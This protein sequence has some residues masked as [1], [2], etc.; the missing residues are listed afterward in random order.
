MIPPER[1]PPPPP[2]A[3][4]PFLLVSGDFVQTGGMDLGNFHLARY[5]ARQG[6][7]VH[8][9]SHRVDPELLTYP[10][11]VFHRAPRPCGLHLSGER[12]LRRLGR[13]VASEPALKGARCVVNGGNC[14]LPGANWVHYV[15]AASQPHGGPGT[16]R[17]WKNRLSHRLFLRDEA[18]ALACARLIIVNSE[19]TRDDL[20]RHYRLPRERLHLVYYGTDPALFYPVDDAARQT[21]RRTLGLPLHKRLFVFV[22]AL[23]D[24][25][26]GFDTLFAAWQAAGPAFRDA[27][28]LIVVGHGAEL[29]TWQRRAAELSGGSSIRFL[30]FRRDVPDILRACDAFVAPARYEAFGLAVLEALCCG[31][32]AIVSRQAG[33][34]ERYPA[35]WDGLLLNDSENVAELSERLRQMCLQHDSLREMMSGVAA[36]LRTYT[37]DDMSKS[38][39]ELVAR[40]DFCVPSL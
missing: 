21:L 30:G 29:P 8:L 22:G 23:G 19:R 7:T 4:A 26:K 12:F 2:R 37:W 1:T 32:P 36:S 31:L 10:Q 17:R 14:P 34:A 11:V 27:A 28:E 15:H 25:R 6:E 18:R 3:A 13:R 38:I 35:A 33:V 20:I 40:Q 9:V 39:H 5:L 24:R 16:L